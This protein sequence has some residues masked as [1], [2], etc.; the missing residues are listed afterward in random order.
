MVSLPATRQEDLSPGIRKSAVMKSTGDVFS[1]PAVEMTSCA[2]LRHGST[3]YWSSRILV[4]HIQTACDFSDGV[5]S[6]D[7]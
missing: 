3:G 1:D 2:H 5:L 6:Q 4:N 7:G